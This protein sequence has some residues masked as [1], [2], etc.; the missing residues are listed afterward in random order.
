MTDMAKATEYLLTDPE[1]QTEYLTVQMFDDA[2]VNPCIESTY[3]FVAEVI[4]TLISLHSGIQ[5]LNM[6]HFGGDE[7]PGAWEK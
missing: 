2:A 7:V 5:D 3:T 6:Y 4:D 1:D